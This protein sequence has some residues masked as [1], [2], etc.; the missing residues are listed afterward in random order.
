MDT[1]HNRIIELLTFSSTCHRTLYWLLWIS[2]AKTTARHWQGDDPLDDTFQLGLR[3]K[4]AVNYDGNAQ[5]GKSSHGIS[6]ISLLSSYSLSRPLPLLALCIQF[7]T[8]PWI[9]ECWSLHQPNLIITRNRGKISGS[10]LLI[11]IEQD[12]SIVQHV[13]SYSSERESWSDVTSRIP[14]TNEIYN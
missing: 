10:N 8:Y 14:I 11:E 12:E 7:F 9:E 5:E 2:N 13:I 6:L 3:R 4:M 1:F